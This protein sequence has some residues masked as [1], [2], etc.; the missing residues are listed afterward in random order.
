V[1]SLTS[2]QA[3]RKTFELIATAGTARQDFGPLFA[4]LAFGRNAH[5]AQRSESHCNPGAT[6]A[7]LARTR[8][9]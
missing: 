6:Q 1:R 9:F 8:R 3:D 4:A 5:A 2:P 7:A